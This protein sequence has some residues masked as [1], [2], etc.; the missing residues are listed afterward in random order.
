MSE[1]VEVPLSSICAPE[2]PMRLAMDRGGVEELTLSIRA[3]GLLEPLVCKRVAR[4]FEVL[5]GHR[6]LLACRMAPLEVVPC[7]V[8]DGDVEFQRAVM[9]AE[10]VT[11]ADLS[12]VE[13]AHAV[14]AMRDVLGLS[15]RVVAEKLGKSEAWVRGRLDLLTWP[16]LALAAVAAGRAHVS[17]LRPLLDIEDEVERDRLLG[18][19]IDSGATAS[20]TRQWAAGVMGVAGDGLEDARGVTRALLPLAEYVVHMPCF[21]C[22]VTQPAPDLRVVR[23]CDGCL[24]EIGVAAAAQV[25]GRGVVEPA[26]PAQAACDPS[27]SAAVGRVSSEA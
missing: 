23:V 9:L 26:G 24:V 17:S 7:M 19:A 10:N 22:R 25:D 20:V 18:C 4:G 16:A 1:F 14:R 3:L 12:P 15:L 13:E 27:A 6:R 5:A 2:A 21:V 11:R 8:V